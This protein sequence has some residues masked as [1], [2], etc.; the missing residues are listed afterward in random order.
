LRHILKA[1][2]VKHHQSQMQL[3]LTILKAPKR[4][5]KILVLQNG[6]ILG[7]KAVFLSRV[8]VPLK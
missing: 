2:D 5:M 4:E 1:N 6:K 8:Q 7:K 3:D